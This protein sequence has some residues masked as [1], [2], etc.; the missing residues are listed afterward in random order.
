MAGNPQVLG[1]LE[2]MLDSGKTPEEVCRDC[3]ELLSEVRRRWREFQLFDAQVRTLLPGLGTPPD[4]GAPMPPPVGLPRVPG[5]EV[6]AVLGY[7]GMGVVYKARQNALDRPVALKMVLAGPFAGSQELGR[8]RRETAALACLRHPNIVQVYDAGEVEGRP[9]FTM[10]LIEG[11]SLAQRL[12][13]TPQPAREAAA[14]LATLAEAVH[15]AHEAGIV[16]RDL[17]P[18]NI[19]LTADGTPRIADFGLARRLEGGAGLTQSGVAVGTPSY[20]APEQARG[21]A[22][23]VGPAVDVHALGAILYE[24]LTGR[25]PFHAETPEETVWQ[26]IHQEPVPP[27]QLIFKVPGD[28]ETICL[29]CLQKDPGRRYVTA[30]H[31]AAD[32]GRF[33]RHEPIQARPTGRVERLVRWV[34]RHPAAAG[35]LAAVLGFVLLGSVG[36]ALQFRQWAADRDRQA[37]TD[38]EV[39]GVLASA[40]GPLE[41]GWPAQDL[42][43]LTAA[44][45]E[46]NRASDIA[47]SGAASAAVRQEAEAFRADADERLRR[48][49]RNGALREA[50]LDVATPQEVGPDAPDEGGRLA[51]PAQATVDE[52]YAAAFR[53][54][55]LDVDGTPEAEVVARVGAEPDA[56]VPELIAAV[57]G[58]M[59]ERRRR[60]RP[61]PEWRRLF[62]VAERLDRSERRRW[63]RT[64]LVGESAPRPASV[65]GLVA[66]GPLWP[67]LWGLARG[68]AWRRLGEVRREID[69]RT[70]PVLTVVLMAQAY[71]AVGDAAGAEQVLGEAAT[72]RPDNVVLL[73]ALAN[74]L[75]RQGPTRRGHAIEYYRAARAQRPRLGIALSGALI[76][77][78][79][80]KEAEGILRSLLPQQPQ[81]PNVLIYLGISLDKQMKYVSA[82]AAYRQAIALAP[83]FAGA[84][85]NLGMCL[86]DQQKYD[87]AERAC[88]KAVDLRPDWADGYYFLGY[89]LAKRRKPAAEEEA[90]RQAI[91]HRPDWAEA[92][93]NL[94]N[95]MTRQGKHG[96]AEAAYRRATELRPNFALAY[97]N[98]GMALSQQQKPGVAEAFRQAI[99]VQHDFPEAHNN[100]GMVLADRRRYSEAEA[101]FRQAIALRPSFAMPHFNLACAVGEQGRFDEALTF[102]DKGNELLP[103]RAP[104]REQA[105]PLLLRYQRCKALDRRLPAV[106]RGSDQPADPA[107]LIAFAELCAIKQFY[108]AAARFY[109]DAFTAE[110]KLAE[111]V[112]KG[113]R[114]SAA[115]AAAQAGCGRGRDTATLDE[116]A[117]AGR[118]RQ[119][120]EWLRQDLAWWG[121]AL[122]RGDARTRAEVRW[123][124]HSWQTDS[125][126]AG[127]REPGALAAMSPDERN[128]CLALWQELAA[129]LRHVQTTE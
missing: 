6:E 36:G 89:I 112:P 37:Q 60:K 119:A 57:D 14:L 73:N 65:A 61:E 47:R 84:H 20:M 46:T 45:A 3:P 53:R 109:S 97:N 1:L 58:W 15:V 96:E 85:S 72:A 116:K 67:A 32:L 62:R 126:L 92:Y 127:L 34:R 100:L 118:R 93:Y 50:V 105:R 129:V 104:L 125:D 66:T 124:M 95:A 26:V 106:L 76:R 74:L 19:L 51:A 7:G 94:G 30:A 39:R 12:A 128:E 102:L 70:D 113:A 111:A 9:Y 82:E 33:L 68:D 117:R 2:E 35:L 78:G 48:A 27:A 69:P 63:L 91:T 75:D 54:W 64:L 121:K 71:A 25:P 24:V 41:E 23:A 29:K 55:G 52:Q 40:R 4:A 22:R 120:R 103:A 110:P 87:A 5:Y 114:Y 21:E 44:Q 8:F 18:A 115:C 31:L 101:A 86:A 17:K 90:Y 107:E 108:A 42:V 28:L 16:H 80:T 38:R 59:L 13:G 11:G 77:N 122:N 10:E 43:K 98:L 123:R 83:N 79:R 49:K 81:N 56:V 88:R 99:A